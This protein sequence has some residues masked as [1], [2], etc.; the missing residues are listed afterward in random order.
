MSLR[1]PSTQVSAPSIPVPV[2]VPDPVGFFAPMLG[3]QRLCDG[4]A[5]NI[6]RPDVEQY[7]VRPE[8]VG[9]LQCFLPIA[10]SLHVVS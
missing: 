9:S 10:G 1:R 8:R 4:F 2:P 3:T 6:R 5:V 7:D